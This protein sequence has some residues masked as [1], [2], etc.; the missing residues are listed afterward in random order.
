MEPFGK[1]IIS[2]LCFCEWGHKCWFVYE[3]C[4]SGY[5]FSYQFPQIIYQSIFVY[6][7]CH[8]KTFFFKN[9]EHF[10]LGIFKYVYIKMFFYHIGVTYFCPFV[11]EVKRVPTGREGGFTIYFFCYRTEHRFYHF[12]IVSIVCICPV[13]F[14]LVKFL[15]VF[16]TQSFIAEIW[17]DRKYFFKTAANK[18]FLI[19][20]CRDPQEKILIKC[21]MMCLKGCC[22]S[23]AC[24]MLEY[25]CFNFDKACIL[26]EFT[27]Y[28][29]KF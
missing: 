20:F 6:G 8:F 12:H 10:F 26:Q 28:C 2:G 14:D 11:G 22:I 27:I 9:S 3:K 4:W 7:T 19:Q 25:W 18:S 15:E 21:I 16:V 1:S 24:D 13:P 5:F 29:P 17:T 23:A